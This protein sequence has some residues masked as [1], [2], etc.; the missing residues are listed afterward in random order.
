LLGCAAVCGAAHRAVGG[1]VQWSQPGIDAWS[2][3]R[4][5]FSE[6]G[7]P[8]GPTFIGESLHANEQNT[9]FQPGTAFMP[10]RTA[11]TIVAFD[12]SQY[13]EPQLPASQY[14]IA[15]VTV[16][17]TMRDATSD[18]VYYYAAGPANPPLTAQRVFEDFRDG[19]EN[20]PRPIEMYGVG[21]TEGVTGFDFHGTAPGRFSQSSLA[22]GANGYVAYP[23]VGD[24]REAGAYRDVSNNF[25]GGF[26]ATES[27]GETDAFDVTPWAI[28][29][30]N[31]AHGQQVPNNTTFS[32]ALELSEPG[33]LA[34]VQQS[35]AEG[36]LGFSFSSLHI[37]EE[38]GTGSGLP[39]PQWFMKES[40]GTVYQGIAATLAIDYEIGRPGDYDIDGDVDGADFLLWQRQHGAAGVPIGSGADGNSDGKVDGDDLAVWRS[41][42]GEGDFSV[43]AVGRAV[44]EPAAWTTAALAFAAGVA[45]SRPRR[46]RAPARRSGFTLVE[47][48]IVIAILGVLIAMLLPAV[49]AAR[50]ASRRITCQN[51]LKQIGLAGQNYTAAMNHLPPPKA[52]NSTTSEHGSMFVLLLPYLE[53]ANRFARYD[54]TKTIHDEHNLPITS[55]PVGG[56]LCPSMTLMR[57]VP[58]PACGEVLA[59]GSYM[60]SSRTR[61]DL[62][63][64]L[65]GAF[66]NPPLDGHYRLSMQ[67]ITD[68]ASNTLFVGET[69]YSHFKMLWSGCPGLDGSTKWGDQTWAQ[70]YW[71]YA[72]GHMASDLPSLFNNSIDYTSRDSPRTFRSD[73][74]GGVQFVLL[75]ASVRFL[76]NET[77]AAVRKALVTRAEEEVDHSFN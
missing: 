10:G 54:V 64:K 30:A 72:W 66:E 40:V 60:I 7:R 61:Y 49:Q 38:P 77:D 70:G 32:F 27:S 18:A 59:P 47:L 17:L 3:L 74:V 6:P 25:T 2:Y 73:H 20:P 62:W 11:T 29:T 22:Y 53:E 44:P 41:H 68:G 14:R 35:L 23:V 51:N 36:G 48:L 50:E 13:I 26:S 46:G 12:T 15:S 65:D 63:T 34:Y 55:Q 43:I 28:G 19:V 33:V 58:E 45:S 5:S 42:F 16:T 69:N 67:Q 56:F 76:R 1:V 39:Y 4:A 24:I 57:Q 8:L 37:A 21:F 75:D 52:G 9:G 71:V 31:L